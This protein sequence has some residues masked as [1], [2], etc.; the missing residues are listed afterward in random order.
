MARAVNDGQQV[1]E[2]PENTNAD[3]AAATAVKAN[4]S[5]DSTGAADERKNEKMDALEP[6]YETHEEKVVTIV[7]NV[8]VPIQITK[9]V[10]YPVEK[11]VRRHEC[12]R[13]EAM[14]FNLFVYSC[15]FRC[16]L[17]LESFN[18]TQWSKMCHT[19]VGRRPFLRHARGNSNNILVLSDLQ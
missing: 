12:D 1:T 6:H 5:Q 19:Q 18:P 14:V 3:G 15:R 16:L 11:L 2:N 9:H 17:K 7:K 8:P 10:P 4:G 13:F